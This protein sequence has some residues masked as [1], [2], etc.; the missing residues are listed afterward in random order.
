MQELIAKAK[1]PK[2]IK[3]KVTDKAKAS[4]EFEYLP[5]Q[6]SDLEQEQEFAKDLSFI[7]MP[8]GEAPFEGCQ[9]YDTLDLPEIIHKERQPVK[10]VE[11]TAET[12]SVKTPLMPLPG[13]PMP[14]MPFM[15]M[16]GMS[17]PQ[18][19]GMPIP[20]FPMMPP[21]PFPFPGMPFIRPPPPKKE[22]TQPKPTVAVSDI[23][24]LQASH[25][26]VAPQIRDLQ[27]ESSVFV[28]LAIRKRK[29]NESSN[30]TNDT[31]SKQPEDAAYLAFMKEINQE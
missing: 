6:E 7:P 21:F 8:Q 11:V 1:K 25:V 17:M 29:F 10:P 16:P 19:Q 31:A 9:I 14:G 30:P 27:K 13:M 5:E 18:I 3:E 4:K 20:P 23:S 24:A 15:P 12:S 2:K 26:S 22:S 28:P